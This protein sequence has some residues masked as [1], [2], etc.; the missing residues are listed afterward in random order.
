M[1]QIND[2]YIKKR[3]AWDKKMRHIISTR[4]YPFN[5][6]VSLFWSLFDENRQ[7]EG[8]AK[9]Q[10]HTISMLVNRLTTEGTQTITNVQGYAL[11]YT[12]LV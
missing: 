6:T 11:S 8:K 12:E 3:R 4:G 10:C 2:T 9:I 1:L 5:R 7:V